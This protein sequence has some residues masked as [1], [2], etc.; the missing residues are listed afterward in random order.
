V[1][2][3]PSLSSSSRVGFVS[4]FHLWQEVWSDDKRAM[5]GIVT[6]ACLLI[7]VSIGY[8]YAIEDSVEGWQLWTWFM[9][10][11]VATFC[12]M[13][14]SRPRLPSCRGWQQ[15]LVLA[16]IALLL[17]AAFLE[18]V[19]GRLHQDEVAMADFALWRVFSEPRR[20]LYPF[21]TGLYSQPALHN[22]IIR[23]SLALLGNSITGL[24]IPS[25]LAGT[26]AVLATYA[27]VKVFENR[28]TAM[29]S[30]IIMTAYHFHIHWSRLGLNN[31]WDTLWVPTMLAAY[32]WGW[33]RRWSGG[34]V[35]AG[36]VLGFSQYFYHGSKIGILLLAYL[37]FW[38][39]RQERDERRLAV[40]IC[41]PLLAA[42]CVAAPIALFAI[43]NPD[44]YFERSR[45][46]FG[47]QLDAIAAA[48]G[49]RMDFW[50]YAWQQLWR[51]AGAFVA[52]PDVTGFYGP[53]VPLTLELAALL[54]VVGV[55]WSVYKRRF[56]PI[57]WI[58]L[59]IL[60]GGFLLTGAPSSSRYVVS[61]PAICWLIA[62]PLEWLIEKGQGYLALG[63]MVA[64]VM[65]DLLFY[66]VVYVPSAP[67]DLIHPFPP[68]PF[69]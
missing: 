32:A 40:F 51:A 36:L 45:I 35:L 50:N 20:T 4:W 7:I 62:V 26:G 42:T 11:V 22:Y 10:V 56:I 68:G 30:A 61:I 69:P 44:S 12:L 28:R 59:T 43:R 65:T 9:C 41:K 24:R 1:T 64:V 52:V 18:S 49:G 13:P 3:A 27:V 6:L 66:F 23:L 39:W 25:V 67:V 34:A 58:L 55:L 15:L 63:L 29:L 33:K 57:L 16:L 37:I 46:V 8:V 60:L 38:L 31:V 19:P 2:F 48:T 14:A 5:R 21:G 53:D 17:R 47:W 54:F